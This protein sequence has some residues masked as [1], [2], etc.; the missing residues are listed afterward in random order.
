M[1][2]T[3]VAAAWAL[4]VSTPALAQ[5][6]TNPPPAGL[7]PFIGAGPEMK[8]LAPMAGT[9]RVETEFFRPKLTRWDKGEAFTALVTMRY[10]GLYIETEL[11]PPFGTQG[12][13][14]RMAFS[15]DKFR[16]TYRMALIENIVGL[17]D[18]FEG[19]FN[20]DTLWVD[21]RRT[22]TMGPNMAG[23]LEANRMA[24]RF[25]GADAFT[26]TIQAWRDN[27]WVDGM[28]YRFTRLRVTG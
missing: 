16:K 1:M 27:G 24:L 18:I 9:W 12:Y 28:R 2:R 17:L 4:A 13:A 5:Q 15:F 20:G 19:G 10:E 3:C 11:V 14:T 26:L 22:G 6:A 21:N 8:R 25:D 7:A 23:Q